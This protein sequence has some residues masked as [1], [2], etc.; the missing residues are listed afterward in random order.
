MDEPR[1]WGLSVKRIAQTCIAAGVALPAMVFALGKRRRPARR[2]GMVIG[3]KPDRMAAYEAL[4]AASHP[5][6]RDLL[7]KYHM[8][9]FSIFLHRLDD[10][11]YYLFAY[12]EY[13][14]R[15]YAADMR[16]LA[17][18]PR[19]RQWLSETDAMQIPLSGEE[20]WA[21]MREVYFNS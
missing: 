18:E 16:R 9:R 5:G 2:V 3:L 11:R 15:D 14:G 6:V 20:T 7:R 19:N 4:H 1:E 10:G 12:F 13:T 8:R 21:I 17:A